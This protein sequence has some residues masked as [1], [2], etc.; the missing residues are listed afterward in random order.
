M[1][2]KAKE[3]VTAQGWDLLMLL[4]DLPSACGARTRP[5]EV[6]RGNALC[7]RMAGAMEE[8]AFLGQQ[9]S[10]KCV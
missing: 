1:K 4:Y 6:V 7:R 2:L 3:L 5:V 9:A 8:P 10:A